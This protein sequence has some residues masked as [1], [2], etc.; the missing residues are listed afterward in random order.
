ME[1]KGIKKLIA[2]KEELS[3]Y[4]FT[5]SSS[6]DKNSKVLAD[7]FIYSYENGGYDGSGFAVWRYKRKWR[8]HYLGHCSCYG[9]MEGIQ[10]S[11][12]A[13]FTLEQIKEILGSNKSWCAHAKNVLDYLKKYK[14]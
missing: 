5:G 6:K 2:L 9:P 12:N 4:D 10:Y 7:V 11:D 14:K 1:I 8:Y 13:T 3:N